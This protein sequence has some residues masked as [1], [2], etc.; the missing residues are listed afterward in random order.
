MKNPS[1]L[2]STAIMK[3]DIQGF[4]KKVEQLS[5]GELS[6]LLDEHKQ[7]IINKVYKYSGSIIKGEGDS[8]WIEF[9]NVTSAVQSAIEIQKSLK[10]IRVES[11]SSSQL[12]IRIAITLGD[13]LHK[14]DD[15]F[16]ESIN[17]ASRIEE[18]TPPNEIYL[19]HAACLILIKKEINVEFVGDY[20]FKGID[21]EEKVYR[22]ELGYKTLIIDDTFVLFSDIANFVDITGNLP[23][24]EKVLDG[25]DLLFQYIEKNYDGNIVN[26]EGDAYI[27][28]F[29][30]I[31]NLFNALNYLYD[32]W[33]SI[34]K[35]NDI[36]NK[37]RLGCHK[38]KIQIYRSA[39]MGTTFNI[40]AVLEEWAKRTK[41]NQDPKLM[42]IIH[43]TDK[44]RNDYIKNNSN[45]KKYFRKVKKNELSEK[46]N[47]SLKKN[48]VLSTYIY[49]PN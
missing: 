1:R 16:G 15:V 43:L 17:L 36:P 35:K 23:L 22:I 39:I 14:D 5:E 19:S 26:I 47:K 27:M 38:G 33:S 40:A 28:R 8:F 18:I 42:T 45:Q 49:C 24:F 3:T 46:M 30:D 10:E 2:I 32:G 13:V 20:K 4:S 31:E 6:T 11:K 9:E 34:C 29:S 37:L 7:F 41:E 25:S 21:N 48:G 44:V 12:S